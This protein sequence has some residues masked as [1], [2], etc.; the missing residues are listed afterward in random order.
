MPVR[1]TGRFGWTAQGQQEMHIPVVL[2]IGVRPRIVGLLTA[3]GWM[4]PLHQQ[5]LIELRRPVAITQM[6]R[7]PA[8][9]RSNI[10][11]RRH[12]TALSLLMPVAEHRLQVFASQRFSCCT[13]LL[14][15]TQQ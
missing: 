3:L 10:P 5:A 1:I 6:P 14:W 9:P 4:L 12:T 2:W 8:F 15:I 11:G 7:P 13:L